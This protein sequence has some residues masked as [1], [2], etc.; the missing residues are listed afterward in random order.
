MIAS[1]VFSFAP[2]NIKNERVA[3][4]FLILFDLDDVACLDTPPISDLKALVP[5]C[6]YKLL[7][8]LGIDL[9]G[10]LFEVPVVDE[11]EEA[12]SNEGGTSNENQVICTFCVD[13]RN[14]V[15]AEM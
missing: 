3:W 14:H 4:Y 7:H 10:R 13:S 9:V 2:D 8:R 1:L 15:R 6:E 12:C 5:L 11:V